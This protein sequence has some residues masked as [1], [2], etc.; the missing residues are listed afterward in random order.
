VPL[1]KNNPIQTV[2][3]SFIE[4]TDDDHS[5]IKQK[6][7][8][9][10]AQPGAFDGKPEAIDFIAPSVMKELLPTDMSGGVIV[11]DY[12]VEIGGTA[13]F[14]RYCRSFFAE[15]LSGN[16]WG[17]MLDEVARG[18]F[19]NGDIDI[20]IHVRPASTDIELQE[21]SRRLR[22]ILSDMA[23]E[24]D[25][26]KVDAMRDEIAD[27]KI[28]QKKLRMEI[29]R[30][31]K[32]T[33]Q[34][35]ASGTDLKSFKMYCNALVKRFS[36]KSI[37]LRPA[38]GKQLEALKAM[39][40]IVPPQG[41]IKE[42]FVT[43][44]SSNLADFFPYAQGGISHK[45]GVIIGLDGLG[46]PV[47]FDQWHPSLPN[48]H[49]I[50][51]GRSGAG[52]TYTTQ[53]IMHRSMHIGRV[54]ASLDWKGEHRDFFL[55]SGLPY[56]EFSENTKSRINPYD[57]EVTE[58]VDGTRYIDIESASNNVQALAFKM[59]ATYDRE[60]LK[61]RVKVFIGS[62]IRE[63]YAEAGITKDFRSL[64]TT[65]I[66]TGTISTR[67]KKP[68]PELGGLYLKMKNSSEEE[69][70]QAAEMLKPFTRHGNSPSYAIFDGQSTVE[71]KGY[72]GY[73]FALNRLDKDIMRPIGLA[74][75]SIWLNENFAKADVSQEKIIF[76]EE[77][78]NIL[79]DPDVGGPFAETAYREYR[80]SNVGV[81]AVTQGLEVLIR[82][83]AGIAALKNSPI[84][85]IGKQENYDI[86]KIQGQL[87]L[88]EGEAGFLLGAKTGQVILKIEDESDIVFTKASD[89]EHMMF[90]TD[91]NDPAFWRRKELLKQ[92]FGAAPQGQEDMQKG[93]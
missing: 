86:D 84:K 87:Y 73:G 8:R 60:V 46:R 90:T 50:I 89:Y 79:D 12:Y 47:F 57:V 16:T 81:C 76:I 15:I 65:Q 2:V 64:Y 11:D 37:Y 75:I 14:K 61:G 35:L 74:A 42:H 18:N 19:G 31:F 28:R 21:L 92:K 52:K 9:K 29:E 36:G 70:Q 93:A 33:I 4:E 27:I 68:M 24:G 62:A 13:T 40:P 69:I 48:Q 44:E 17:G 85:I 63:Q 83:N 58:D 25:P 54:I 49:M 23:L 10:Q 5:P 45:T 34:I 6:V 22:G 30:T 72:P 71:L 59:I 88:S 91:P 78:Q 32:T 26:T 80:A 3:K 20:A 66:N 67:T 77:A 41:V 1:L 56:I 39:L 82:S 55:L 43:L 53:I 51:L 7:K 38:D